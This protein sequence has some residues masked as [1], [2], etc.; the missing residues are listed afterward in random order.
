[1]P[2]FWY[3][4][5]PPKSGVDYRTFN[6]HTDTW[7]FCMCIHAGSWVCSLILKTFCRVNPESDLGELGTDAKPTTSWAPI[8]VVTTL[9]CAQHLAHKSKCS[10]PVL[11][12]LWVLTRVSLCH[13][14]ACSEAGSLKERGELSL[15]IIHATF[16]VTVCN[17]AINKYTLSMLCQDECKSF[18]TTGLGEGTAACIKKHCWPVWSF[19][20]SCERQCTSLITKSSYLTL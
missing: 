3:S 4:H 18:Q 17:L 1:M 5:N 2:L 16:D 19:L 14:H 9:G 10:C 20:W 8:D 13:F 6:V 11:M 7:S 12:T 15:L